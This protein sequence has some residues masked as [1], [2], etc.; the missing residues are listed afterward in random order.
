MNVGRPCD[1]LILTIDPRTL[2]V[3]LATEGATLCT[4]EDLLHF[5]REDMGGNWEGKLA[6]FYA[7]AA[8][9]FGASV[10]T[11]RMTFAHPKKREGIALEDLGRGKGFKLHEVAT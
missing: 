4:V 8:S 3:R 1:P 7:K 2:R 6:D 5:L 11:I 9:H 10:T